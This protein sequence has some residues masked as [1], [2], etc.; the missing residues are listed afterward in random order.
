M[1]KSVVLISPDF[2]NLSTIIKEEIEKQGYKCKWFDDRPSNK[3]L[4]KMLLRLSS[5]SLKGKI[6]RYFDSIIEYCKKEQPSKFIV[7]IGQCF[8]TKHYQKLRKELPN[9]ELVFYNWD[10]IENFPITKDNFTF[11]DR[12]YSFD[13]TDCKKYN[14]DFLPLFY[15][16]QS[17][18]I[19]EDLD[20]SIITTVK[21]GKYADLYNI[22]SQLD[23]KYSNKFAHLYLQSKSMFNYYKMSDKGFKL[24]KKEEFT[25]ERLSA[26]KVQD[27]FNRSKIIVDIVM[28]KQS[29]LTI[30]TIDTLHLKKKLITNN[31]NIKEYPFYTEQN[32]LV[33]KDGD[34]IDFNSKFFTEPFDDKYCIDET[35]SLT[36]FVKKL[37]GE[38]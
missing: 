12:S 16:Y 14:I 20:Y 15:S 7:I 19:K 18:N 11:F 31:V 3:L 29:G 37:L 17:S 28:A 8:N 38:K 21:K 23:K 22:I 9:M 35:Y 25:T 13:L 34:K 24:A 27:V 4:A 30:R 10:S 33:C 5:S 26:D 32:I 1:D 6:N 36:S 2:F